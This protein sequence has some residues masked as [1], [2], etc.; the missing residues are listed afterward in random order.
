MQRKA[1]PVFLSIGL[2]ALVLGAALGTAA[3]A[4]A[5]PADE[6]PFLRQNQ[7]QQAAAA[8]R[9][10][11]AQ[12][13]RRYLAEQDGRPRPLPFELASVQ[14]LTRAAVGQGF[15]VHTVDP[16][17]VLAGRSDVAGMVRPT[18]EWRF[19]VSVDE[20]PV[21][22]VTVRQAGGRWE[23]VS[24][25]AA[26]LSKEVSGLMARHGN[27]Q[28]SNL[29]FVRVLQARSDFLEV[30]SEKDFGKRYAPLKSARQSLSLRQGG[31][32]EGRA[33]GRAEG[34]GLID[35]GEFLEPLRAA[36]KANMAEF[37]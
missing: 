16:A 20:R 36:I 22:L 31:R 3:P 29:R 33:E 17:D 37:R 28:R 19:V 12:L 9:T 34:D 26:E 6:N 18:G 5:R 35:G 14:D 21:G 24:F 30:T 13:T 32:P 7:Q 25:G 8:A 1:I 11:L 15:E 4:G 2:S 10:G 23:A 27:A